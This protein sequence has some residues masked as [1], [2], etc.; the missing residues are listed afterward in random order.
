VQKVVTVMAMDKRESDGATTLVVGDREV[1]TAQVVGGKTFVFT[2]NQMQ[3]LV[4]LQ[5][6]KSV[7]AAAIGVGKDEGWGRSFLKSR[8]FTDY[9]Y[10]KLEEQ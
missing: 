1:V 2:P 3:F 8:K 10:W 4:L 6:L 5:R 9:L 7:A